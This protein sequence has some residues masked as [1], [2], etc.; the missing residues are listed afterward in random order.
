MLT[1]SED[2][3]DLFVHQ[4]GAQGYLLKNLEARS[5]DRCSKA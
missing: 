1:V 3:A 2:E 4:G 5:Y